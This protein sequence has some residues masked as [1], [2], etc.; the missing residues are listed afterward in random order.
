MMAGHGV[1]LVLLGALGVLPDGAVIDEPG[2]YGIAALAARHSVPAY[3]CALSSSLYAPGETTPTAWFDVT[4]ADLLTGFVT[5]EGI[6]RPPFETQ[7]RHLAESPPTPDPL[8]PDWRDEG[9]P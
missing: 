7:L 1:D 6:V 8:R 9:R 2:A 4:P 3:V 5:D